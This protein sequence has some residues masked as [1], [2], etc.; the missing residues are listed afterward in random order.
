[1][2]EDITISRELINRM[3]TALIKVVEFYRWT[4]LIH[5]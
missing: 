5:G 2:T 4:I 1:M 3:A